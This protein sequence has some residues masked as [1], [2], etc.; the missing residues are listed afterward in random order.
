[1][2]NLNKKIKPFV[3]PTANNKIIDAG[4]KFKHEVDMKKIK[5]LQE[6]LKYFQIEKEINQIHIKLYKKTKNMTREQFLDYFNT[7]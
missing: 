6:G 4:R 2:L 1:M 7:E 5:K 3:A